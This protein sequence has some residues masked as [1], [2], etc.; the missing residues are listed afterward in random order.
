MWIVDLEGDGRKEVVA[1]ANRIY[2]LEADGKLRWK[3]HHL[4]GGWGRP[5]GDFVCGAIADLD[6]DG[7]K[8]VTVSYATTYSNIL[9]YNAKGVQVFPGKL[10]GKGC[11]PRGYAI[12]IPR[13]LAVV[14]LFG[15]KRVRQVVSAADGRLRVIWR[16][17]KRGE[18]N[19]ADRSANCLDM[20]VWQPDPKRP[21]TVFVATRMTD[22]R[23]YGRWRV[24]GRKIAVDVLWR[25]CLGEKATDLLPLKVGAREALFLGTKTGAVF[26]FDLAEGQ[27]L[28]EA[29]LARGPIV[30]LRPSFDGQAVLAVLADG[31]VVRLT[32]TW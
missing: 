24:R 10:K 15:G 3:I 11:H 26:A 28:A 2:C 5:V 13:R 17:Q 29:R 32:P 18:R 22:V 19:G 27:P 16:D 31:R 12:G 6:G 7:K 4:H 1:G 21:A 8:D 20:A 23:A 14:D 9:S 25:R 30:Q